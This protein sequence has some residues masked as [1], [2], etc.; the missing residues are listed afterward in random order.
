MSAPLSIVIPTLNA[1]SALPATADAL[2]EGATSGLVMDMVISDGGSTDET[3]AVAEALG[4]TW[5]DG[6]AGRGGQIQRGVEASRGT[7]ILILHADTHLSPGWAEAVHTH[8]QGFPEHAG[9]FD[10]RFR[11]TGLMPALVARAATLRS[12]W[13]DLPY[14]DQGLLIS[15]ELLR[16]VG[17]MPDLPLMEDVALARLLRGRLRRLPA[18]AYTSAARYEAEGWA[19]RIASNLGTL[20]RYALGTDPAKLK[21]RYER[22]A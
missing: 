22:K 2:L 9:W 18:T 14:G 1:A 16:K 4:A 13:L 8:I 19:R 15:H 7:W 5:I 12:R 20:A 11:A 3:E 10:L 17:G 6:S 21:A